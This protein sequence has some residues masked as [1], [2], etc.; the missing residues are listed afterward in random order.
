M[1]DV[2]DLIFVFLD[3]YNYFFI[4]TILDFL[5]FPYVNLHFKYRKWQK[6][7]IVDKIFLAITYGIWFGVIGLPKIIIR[8]VRRG[9]LFP[10]VVLI[11][12]FS[13]LLF[14]TTNYTENIKLLLTSWLSFLVGFWL[15]KFKSEFEKILLWN[16]K[17]KQKN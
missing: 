10:I 8:D 17:M 6:N 16:R 13:I 3:K 15:A 9:N 14:K 11:I 5:I 12:F 4:A 1:V 2:I 7:S